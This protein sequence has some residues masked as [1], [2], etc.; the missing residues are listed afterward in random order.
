MS[1]V[2]TASDIGAAIRAERK[3]QGLTQTEL[4]DL[5]G[6]SLSF[7]SNLENGKST[8]ELAKTLNVI[9]TLGL[10][11]TFTKRGE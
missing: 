3:S 11:V 4:A 2:R 8:T 1:P 9:S 5:C 7:I 6:V 10:D